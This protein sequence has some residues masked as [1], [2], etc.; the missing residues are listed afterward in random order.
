MQKLHYTK[1]QEQQPE[2][3]FLLVDLMLFFSGRHHKKGG[4][5]KLSIE[6]MCNSM[7]AQGEFLIISNFIL[8]WED[9]GNENIFF[10]LSN[11]TENLCN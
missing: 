11:I 1:D 7:I 10:L 3:Y 2:P 4:S 9:A 6:W 8:G 5:V